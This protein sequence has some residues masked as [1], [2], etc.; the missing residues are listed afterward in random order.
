MKLFNRKTKKVLGLL[1]CF[2]FI[3]LIIRSDVYAGAVGEQFM[4]RGRGTSAVHGAGYM[5]RGAREAGNIARYIE[6][7]I[8]LKAFGKPSRKPVLGLKKKASTTVA[9]QSQ[10]AKVIT[11]A[12]KLLSKHI[13]LPEGLAGFLEGQP[14]MEAIDYKSLGLAV[15]DEV[16][17]EYDGKKRLISLKDIEGNRLINIEYAANG[18]VNMIF[19]IKNRRAI[20]FA[21]EDTYTYYESR[22]DYVGGSIK[23]RYAE[24]EH[25]ASN[26]LWKVLNIYMTDDSGKVLTGKD[27]VN[28]HVYGSGYSY[29]YKGYLYFADKSPLVPYYSWFAPYVTDSYRLMGYYNMG[30]KVKAQEYRYTDDGR[31]KSIRYNAWTAGLRNGFAQPGQYTYRIDTFDSSGERS[32]KWYND[33]APTRYEPTFTGKV[34]KDLY[35]NYYIK[36]QTAYDGEGKNVSQ[37]FAGEIFL[38]T[39]RYTD[40]TATNHGGQPGFNR[41]R[42]QELETA[43]QGGAAKFTELD[44]KGLVGKSIT[45]QGHLMTSPVSETGLYYEGKKISVFS[46]FDVL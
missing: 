37:D 15:G 44:W 1:V 6:R 11:S 42:D 9:T 14:V 35:N 10:V 22:V 39:T 21:I 41:W 28:R 43:Y 23:Y 36:V 18:F 4:Y 2:I 20:E 40:T 12:P 30:D 3:A 25:T 29:D 33:P 34:K 45:V 19:D 5:N 24:T 17:Y 38:L 7:K 13:K 27:I 32:I 16:Q 8:S 31:L 46:A 26:V